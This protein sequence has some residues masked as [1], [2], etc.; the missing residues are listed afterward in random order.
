MKNSSLILTA[1]A[2]F[3]VLALGG[4]G[5]KMKRCAVSGTVTVDGQPV[6]M[7]AITF[8]PMEGT[9]SPTSGGTI[10]NGAFSIEK[11]AGPAPG[12][13]KAQ[14]T[15]SIKTGNMVDVPGMNGAQME[16]LKPAIPEKYA[17]PLGSEIPEVEISEGKNELKFEF[18][19]EK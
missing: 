1:A 7:G 19:S 4:C 15:G 11:K 12:K 17:Y 18:T 2:I 3:A 13:Y 10:E 5:D 9:Q 16:E 6:Q 8:H 14:L